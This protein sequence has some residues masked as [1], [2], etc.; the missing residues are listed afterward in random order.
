MDIIRLRRVTLKEYVDVLKIVDIQE[1]FD[2]EMCLE[3]VDCC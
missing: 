2:E 1:K 3:I